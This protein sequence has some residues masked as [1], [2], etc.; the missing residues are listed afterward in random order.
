MKSTSDVKAAVQSKSLTNLTKALRALAEELTYQ[1]KPPYTEVK[2]FKAS[3]EAE[4]FAIEFSAIL[5]LH[6]FSLATTSEGLVFTIDFDGNALA[7]SSNPPIHELFYAARVE[8]LKIYG[9]GT[10]WKGRAI[11]TAEKLAQNLEV[12]SQTLNEMELD[13]FSAALG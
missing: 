13:G 10:R 5:H 11:P 1:L 7:D 9:Y 3:E 8:G 4:R 6:Y 12:T 2:Q